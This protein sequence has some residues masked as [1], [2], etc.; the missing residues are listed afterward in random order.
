MHVAELASP[1]R[2]G[3]PA[4]PA[5]AWIGRRLG[6]YRLVAQIAR[7]G[8]GEVYLAERDDGHYRQQVAIKLLGDTGA[9]AS[10]RARFE[11]E[12][13]LLASLDH[14]NIAKLLDA[15][16]S[17]DGTPYFVMEHVRGQAIDR[18]CQGLAT[19]E[20]LQLFRTVCQVVHHAHRGGVVHRDLKPANILVTAEGVVKLV[21]FGIAKQ[22]DAASA[23]TVTARPMMT[24]EYASPEQV[25]GEAV[26]P[27]SDIFSLGVVLYRLL[28]DASPYEAATAGS[29]YALRRAICDTEP[30]LPSRQ[31][32]PLLRRRLRGDLDAVLL[33]ALRKQPAQRYASAEALAD[34]VFRHLEGLPVQ[35]R[36]GAWGHRAGRFL[37]RHRAA[38]GAALVANLA[39]VAGL[40][41][42]AFETYEAH[43]QRERA[44][45]HFASVRKLANVFVFDVDRAIARVPGSLQARKTIVDTAL[46]Y[47]QQLSDE[48]AGDRALQLELA[49]GYR[50]IADIQGAGS[51]GSLGDSAGAMRSYDHALT[52]VQPLMSGAGD[53][54][55]AQHE[56]MMITTRKGILLMAQGR[57][58][59]AEATEASGVA[60]GEALVR[61]EPGNYA[62]QRALGNQ[63]VH[64]LNVYQL[65]GNNERFFPTADQAQQQLQKVNALNAEDIDIVSNLSAVHGMRAMQMLDNDTSAATQR[66]AL[67]EYQHSLAVMQP[68]Y[69]KHPGHNVLATNYAKG[70]SLIGSLL[71]DLGQPKEA[72]VY[73][74]RAVAMTDDHVARDPD[75]VRARN[76]QAQVYE[77]LGYALMAVHDLPGAITAYQ[78]SLTYYEALPATQRNEVLRQYNEGVTH[79]HLGD[80]LEAR[81]K[82]RHDDAAR[83]ADQ[84]AACAHYRR[85][86]ALLLL[87]EKRQPAD[88]LTNAARDDAAKAVRRCDAR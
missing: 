51:M 25:R 6:A 80:A 7:G 15:G 52:L 62:W 10:M 38:V 61:A 5:A 2:G 28:T 86:Q 4:V 73:V 46:G 19:R 27:A 79:H 72:L 29:D 33:M 42:A 45:R 81:A 36:K 37:L 55:A 14:P 64:L 66:R 23:L 47:L 12:R 18:H 43:R 57:W 24:L 31:V 48:T 69:D 8:M 74:R 16:I 84:A 35:A 1:D 53:T 58:Q 75:N 3:A 77:D 21:D 13:R 50:S 60:V 56:Y 68:A 44:E 82:L 88:A 54:R 70:H 40:G 41:I 34:D 11:A 76:D 85:G 30:R 59:E 9:D 32:E 78:R 26:T 71:A 87:N 17:D 49:V 83:R 65:G 39:L 20:I 63:L 22:V 67:V